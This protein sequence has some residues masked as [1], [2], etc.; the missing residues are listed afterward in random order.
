MARMLVGS[1]RE[2]PHSRISRLECTKEDSNLTEGQRTVPEKDETISRA[3]SLTLVGRAALRGGPLSFIEVV[4]I[5]AYFTSLG[6]PSSKRASFPFSWRFIFLMSYG[7]LNR[8]KIRGLTQKRLS[9]VRCPTCGVRAGH[10]YQLQAGGLRT[11][12]HRV[13]LLPVHGP[14]TGL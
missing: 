2:E 11:E 4:I 6:G 3:S 10:R 9:S 7:N 13:K 1:K 5:S 12:P 8:M 14:Q